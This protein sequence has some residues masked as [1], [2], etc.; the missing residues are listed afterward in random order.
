[1]G[2]VWTRERGDCVATMGLVAQQTS[3]T[4]CPLSVRSSMVNFSTG[5]HPFTME[6]VPS[7][8]LGLWGAAAMAAAVTR[9]NVKDETSK[10]Y[11]ERPATKGRDWVRGL[12]VVILN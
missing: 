1:M 7:L 8:F 11:N 9:R 5:T 4:L 2:M 12:G 6:Y 10:T 3:P